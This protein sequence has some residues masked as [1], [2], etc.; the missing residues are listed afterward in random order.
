MARSGGEQAGAVLSAAQCRAARA[1]LTWGQSELSTR[2]GVG[3]SA[4]KD[5]EGE[6]RRTVTSIRGQLRRTFEDA[7]VEFPD[8]HSIRVRPHM[9]A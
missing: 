1:W 2:S 4:I 6:K 9:E 5:F 7:G 8:G 3:T